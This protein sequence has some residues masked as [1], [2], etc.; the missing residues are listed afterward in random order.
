MDHPPD[1][2]P[3]NAAELLEVCYFFVRFE[4]WRHGWSGLTLA[5]R[6]TYTNTMSPISSYTD[7]HLHD[8]SFNVNRYIRLCLLTDSRET[9]L[10][11]P[12]ETC[13][14]GLLLDLPECSTLPLL[15]LYGMVPLSPLL[16]APV[17]HPSIHPPKGQP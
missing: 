12:R 10:H 11:R 6:V 1:A 14:Q 7:K 13:S 4:L 15:H 8:Y 5:C 9:I 17:L 3:V 16:P 2:V